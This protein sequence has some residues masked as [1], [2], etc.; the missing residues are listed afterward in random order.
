M[1][2]PKGNTAA[3]WSESSTYGFSLERDDEAE[4]Y[5]WVRVQFLEE[6]FERGAV[7]YYLEDWVG[8]RLVAVTETSEAVD[9]TTDVK[10]DGHR[11]AANY[12]FAINT[13][14][15]K[16]QE[17]LVLAMRLVGWDPKTQMMR[18]LSNAQ[19]V[20]PRFDYVPGTD[21]VKEEWGIPVGYPDVV[22]HAASG[23]GDELPLEFSVLLANELFKYEEV[24]TVDKSKKLAVAPL[25][26]LILNSKDV[27]SHGEVYLT[28]QVFEDG[29]GT[30]G[31]LVEGLKRLDERATN[32]LPAVDG[33]VFHLPFEVPDVDIVDPAPP[34]FI[35]PARPGE[36][37]R[38]LRVRVDGEERD[39]GHW[40]DYDDSMG[41]VEWMWPVS[42]EDDVAETGFSLPGTWLVPPS[43][44]S[45]GFEPGPGFVGVRNS[46]YGVFFWVFNDAS[47]AGKFLPK[48]RAQLLRKDVESQQ[49]NPV[50]RVATFGKADEIGVETPIPYCQKV[51]LR[52]VKEGDSSE[53]LTVFPLEIPRYRGGYD[54]DPSEIEHSQYLLAKNL[55]FLSEKDHHL[56]FTFKAGELGPGQWHL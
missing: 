43:F 18:S 13:A 3:I 30:G 41:R 37:Q 25:A 26:A 17:S 51:E 49:W 54:F 19:L 20:V 39:L 12:Y 4:G 14:N 32:Q 8:N 1:D 21:K 45:E 6:S 48:P 33:Q 42:E 24:A 36:V 34:N 55:G 23:G 27:V 29:T 47:S 11:F 15:L 53:E 7:P 46:N 44:L 9:D 28:M 40:P 2:G 22:K 50:G 35:A 10:L 38:Y 31:K 5:A 52:A 56:L 16:T